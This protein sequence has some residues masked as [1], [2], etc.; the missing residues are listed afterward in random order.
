MKILKGILYGIIGVVAVA[1]IAALFIKKEYAAEREIII[2]KPLPE[3]F[4]YVK[5][6]KNQDNFSVWAQMDPEMDKSYTGTDGTV[7]FVSSWDS[8]KPSVGKGELEIIRIEENQRIDY[9]LRFYEPFEATDNAY[10]ITEEVSKDQT[11]VKWGFEGKSQYPMNLML[12]LM[13][14]EEMLGEQLEQGLKNL[15]NEMED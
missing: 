4:S 5:Q 10:M 2:E 1:L 9:E 11:K 8:E 14:T 6:L 15:K 7:G 3:V 13:G 12:A